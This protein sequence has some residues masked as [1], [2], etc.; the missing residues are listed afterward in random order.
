MLSAYPLLLMVL[1]VLVVTRPESLGERALRREL[2]CFFKKRFLNVQFFN[3][4]DFPALSL[5]PCLHDLSLVDLQD[6]LILACFILRCFA[7]F[8]VVRT[9]SYRLWWECSTPSTR[10]ALWMLLLSMRCWRMRCVMVRINESL[11]SMN[12]PVAGAANFALEQSLRRV[13]QHIM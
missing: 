6:W 11:G 9:S 8:L 2:G 4:F 3:L 13:L 12:C 7:L 10:W 5:F 1:D